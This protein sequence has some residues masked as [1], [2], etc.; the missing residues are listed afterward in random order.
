VYLMWINGTNVLG[1][2]TENVLF[3]KFIQAAIITISSNILALPGNIVLHCIQQLKNEDSK[4][5]IR[6]NPN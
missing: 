5:N 2:W 3:I 1:A 6:V 4:K